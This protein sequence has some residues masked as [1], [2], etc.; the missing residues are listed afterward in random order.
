[1]VS[2][3]DMRAQGGY[4]EIFSNSG[5]IVAHPD[6]RYLGLDL[7]ETV[8]QE[9]EAVRAAIKNGEMYILSGKDFYTVYMPIQFSEVTNPWSVAVSIPMDAILENAASIWNYAIVVSAV[10]VCVIAIFLYLIVGSSTKPIL[11]LANTAKTFGEGNF[12]AEVPLIRGNNEIGALSRAFKVMTEKINGLITDLQNYAHELEEKNENLNGL[13]EALVTAKGLAETANRAK[14]EFL[15]NMSHEMRTPM[16]AI[17]GMTSIGKSAPDVE[18]KDYAF[19]KIEDASHHLLGVVNDILDMS[20]IEANKLE[21]SSAEF[22]FGRMLSKI[23]DVINFR[24]TEK[25]QSFQMSVDKAIPDRL[26][27]DDQRL[28]QVIM[29]LL[30]NAVKFTPAGG[31]IRMNAHLTGEAEGVCTLQFEVTDTGI[32]ISEEQ[33]EH[34]FNSFQQADS[35]ISRNFGGTGLG[36]AISKRIVELMG[37]RI[38]IESELGKGAVF[39]F[40]VQA[41]RGGTERHSLL[42]PGVNWGNLRVLAVDDDAEV[43]EY[44]KEIAQ[45]FG[46]ACDTASGG[47]AVVALLE[48]GKHY[49]IY[50]IDWKMPGMNGIELSKKIKERCAGNFVVTMISSTEWSLIADEARAAGVDRF[51]P[52]P[53]FPSAIADC[54]NEC[55]GGGNLPAEDERSGAADI[56][57]GCC[58]LLAEDV[59]INREIVLAVLEPTE[60]EIDCAENGAEALRLFGEN[61]ERYDMIFMDLQMPEMDGLEASRQIRALDTPRAKTVPIIAMTANV[62]REDI[63]KCLAAGMN[64]HLGK[65]LDMDALFEKLRRYLPGGGR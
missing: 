57:T 5:S 46:I 30:S 31:S 13:N 20:K 22:D 8:A 39:S 33:Q 56:F 45:G 40:T 32:G 41:T 4:T 42:N 37:G 16:N 26:V 52:K 2:R 38:W 19:G 14:S 7:S 43:L 3:E 10:A 44:F 24:V 21:L 54:I 60:I 35:S 64:D 55:L 18:K 11:I 63:E 61:P 59:E 65:P 49:D 62:F 25:K 51:L 29:N 23:V 12:D 50:F 6:S 47:E 53:L 27:G 34:L 9:T 15:S 17:I 48:E 58:V 36:L 1:M 28:T